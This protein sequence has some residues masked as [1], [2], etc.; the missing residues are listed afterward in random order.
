M[1][2]NIHHLKNIL[3]FL[4]FVQT[5]TAQP[6]SNDSSYTKVNLKKFH[7]GKKIVQIEYGKITAYANQHDYFGKTLKND[8]VVVTPKYLDDWKFVELLE[9]G[10]LKIYRIATE[11]YVPEITY[12]LQKIADV[13]ELFQF[14]DSVVF[15]MQAR[16]RISIFNNPGF[17]FTFDSGTQIA[18]QKIIKK[19]FAYPEIFS[20]ASDTGSVR[21]RDYFP[22]KK[23]RHYIYTYENRYGEKDTLVCKSGMLENKRV[24]YFR[25]A[26]NKFNLYSLDYTF[27]GDGLF[28]YQND[29]LF[30]IAAGYEKEINQSGFMDACVFLPAVCKMGDSSIRVNYSNTKKIYFLKKDSVRV[31]GKIWKDCIKCKMLTYWDDTVYLS[32]FWLQKNVGLVKWMRDTGREDMLNS[33]FDK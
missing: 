21:I 15:F 12:H 18:K 30:T 22:L 11:E 13:F 26:F 27:I 9:K 17:S 7:P 8:T 33:Y 31:A 16:F 20:L 5:A 28:Y 23:N 1:L 3:L 24:F 6:N 19:D 2:F 29:S 14:T 25:E 10:K 4:F 32:Y